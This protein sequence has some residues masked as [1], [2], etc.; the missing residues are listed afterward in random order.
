MGEDTDKAAF[1][2]Q[3][4]RMMAALANISVLV[5]FMGLI[6]PIVIWAT[7]KDKSSFVRFQALQATAYQT[8]LILF[9]FVGMGCYICSFFGT[10]LMIPLGASGAPDSDP[11]IAAFM[12]VTFLVPLC[13][14]GLLSVGYFLL[15]A[16]GVFGAI[17]VFRG[18][19]FRYAIIGRRVEK[20][21]EP[22][23]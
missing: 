7:Q 23:S 2:S 12:G 4:E 17:M 11:L 1:P 22:Q 13:V 18:R 6:A 14:M 20:Y 3:D 16:Y 5:P 8:G 10:F 19:D 21:L 15:I 9:W